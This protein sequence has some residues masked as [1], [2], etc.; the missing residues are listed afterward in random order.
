MSG[1]TSELSNS[2]D[3]TIKEYL[4]MVCDV[5][6]QKTLEKENEALEF[7]QEDLSLEDQYLL[8]LTNIDIVGALDYYY[9][10]S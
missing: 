8:M 6:K 4:Q 5:L 1:I 7:K 2:Q 9:E 3:L 10:W